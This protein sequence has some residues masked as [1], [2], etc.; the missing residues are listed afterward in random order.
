[1]PGTVPAWLVYGLVGIRLDGTWHVHRRSGRHP[2][3]K[4][5]YDLDRGE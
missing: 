4:I 1:M 5:V 2:W 3:L